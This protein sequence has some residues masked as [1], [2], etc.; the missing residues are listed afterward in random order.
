MRV[1]SQNS[2]QGGTAA[3]S[4]HC[5]CSQSCPLSKISAASQ[6]V[7]TRCLA[8]PSCLGACRRW[9]LLWQ[10]WKDAGDLCQLLPVPAASHQSWAARSR[11]CS[12]VCVCV[13]VGGCV[14]VCVCV[15]GYRAI[16]EKGLQPCTL[17]QPVH[18]RQMQVQG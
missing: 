2:L 9:Q 18:H 12:C 11:A 7:D 17:A 4:Y 13:C 6:E 3:D 14:C 10:V 15:C 16:D 8:A 5:S 1:Q